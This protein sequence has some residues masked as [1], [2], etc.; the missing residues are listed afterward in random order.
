M[1]VISITTL[2]I[3]TNF[4]QILGSFYP[5]SLL[6]SRTAIFIASGAAGTMFGGYIQSG[7]YATLN[8]RYGLAGWR[9]IF[10]VDAIITVV[11]VAIIGFILPDFPNNYPKKNFF[12]INENMRY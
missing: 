11:P 4:I 9:W 3:Y 1:Y 5:H 10:I 12:L 7:V 6:S 8:G 2:I